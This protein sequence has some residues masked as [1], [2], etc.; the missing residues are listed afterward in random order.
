MKAHLLVIDPQNDFCDIPIAKRPAVD[1]RVLGP[2]LAVPGA[3]ADMQRLAAFV[4]EHRNRIHD[5]TVTLDSHP[6]V[7]VERTT[8][9]QQATGEA[10]A[11]FTAIHSIDLRGGRFVPRDANKR[12]AVLAMLERLEAAGRGPLMVWPVHCVTGT[13][14]HNIVEDF[15]RELHAWEFAHQRNAHRVLKGEYPLS[16]HYGVFRA[17]VEY[18][19]VPSTR[20]N[21]ALARRVTDGVELL[22]VAGEASSHCVAASLEQL[23]GYLGDGRRPRIVVLTDCMSPVAG[24]ETAAEEYFRRAAALGVELLASRD[25]AALLA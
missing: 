18:A 14:G 25:A 2:A 1:G 6:S 7:A 8:F 12:D 4:G 16:E 17:E 10:V 13:W 15:A 20:F 22:L 11:P 21:E 5:V 24:F 23:L 19:D 9:W 3:Y